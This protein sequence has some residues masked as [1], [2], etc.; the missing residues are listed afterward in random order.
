M[1]YTGKNMTFT[2]DN[3]SVPTIGLD[4]KNL[5]EVRRRRMFAFVFDYLIIAFLSFIAGVGVFFLGIITLGLGWLLYGMIIPVVAALYFVFTL[6]GPAQAT[7]GMRFFS[8]KLVRYDGQPIDVLNSILHLFLFWA[9]NMV[10][11]FFILLVSLFSADK[12]LMH[13]ILLGTVMVRTDI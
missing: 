5:D 3:T 7:P 8:L 12:R 1:I 13:D 4:D 11:P 10:L 9:G 6:A 2:D